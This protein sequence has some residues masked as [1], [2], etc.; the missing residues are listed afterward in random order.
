MRSTM[1]RR[2]AKLETERGGAEEY[3]DMSDWPEACR[4]W[5]ITEADL[6]AI[7]KDIDGK[8]RGLPHAADGVANLPQSQNGG[9]NG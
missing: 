3:L 1:K 9:F 6:R 7:L 2:L 8:T 4:D 5:K